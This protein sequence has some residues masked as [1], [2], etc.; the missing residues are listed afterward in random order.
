MN[1]TT[2][3]SRMLLLFAG[4]FGICAWLAGLIFINKNSTD[5]CVNKIN[6]AVEYLKA[7]KT[8]LWVFP[9][10][11]IKIEIINTFINLIVFYLRF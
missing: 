4:P 11:K 7:K 8:K 9:E 6:E 10:G 2:V 5:G 3:I 1:K